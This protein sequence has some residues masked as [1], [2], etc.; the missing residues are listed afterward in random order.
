MRMVMG[1]KRE[2]GFGIW[3]YNIAGGLVRHEKHFPDSGFPPNLEDWHYDSD[4]QVI[5]YERN[6]PKQSI[7]YDYRADGDVIRYA[8]DLDRD[9]TLDRIELYKYNTLHELANNTLDALDNSGEPLQRIWSGQYDDKGNLVKYYIELL[10]CLDYNCQVGVS[11]L[12]SP[13]YPPTR[14]GIGYLQYG[15]YGNLIRREIDDDD[16]GILDSIQTRAYNARGSLTS[17]KDRWYRQDIDEWIYDH[18]KQ[19]QYDADG[20]LIRSDYDSRR[21][22]IFEHSATGWGHIFNP[23]VG[24]PPQDQPEYQPPMEPMSPTTLPCEGCLS[25]PAIPWPQTLR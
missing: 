2:L 14:R 10:G 21:L 24:R 11:D 20:Y 17:Y 19:W 23:R 13:V 1:R 3:Q 9:G 15:N 8:Q 4:G 18:N 12:D 6:G 22:E 5:N 25:S 7:T 16:D